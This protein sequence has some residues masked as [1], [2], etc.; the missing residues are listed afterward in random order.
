VLNNNSSS[1]GATACEKRIRQLVETVAQISLADRGAK[2][3]RGS[4]E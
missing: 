3:R 2:Q 4:C 1:L